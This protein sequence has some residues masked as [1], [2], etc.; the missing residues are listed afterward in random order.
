MMRVRRPALAITAS[1][2]RLSAI[3]MPSATATRT[4]RRV[5]RIERG[6]LGV[7]HDQI[8][9]GHSFAVVRPLLTRPAPA[10]PAASAPQKRRRE[11]S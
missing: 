5:L 7:A 1:R 3:T 6:D 11:E 10:T 9:M 2:R 8:A 4:R